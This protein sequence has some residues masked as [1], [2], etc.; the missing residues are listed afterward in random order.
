MSD[1]PRRGAQPTWPVLDALI[2]QVYEA[3]LDPTLWDDTLTGITTALGPLEWDLAFLIW[4]RNQ[5]PGA[6]FVGSTGLAAWVP[7]IYGTVYA[8]NNPW[9]RRIAPLRSGTVVDTDELMTR[10]EFT[11]SPLYR[12]FLSRWGLNRALAVVLDRR[13]DER[14]ALVLPG[15][16]DRDL[17][18]LRRGLRVLAPHIQRAVRISHRI[19]QAE[20]R[21]D[22]ASTAA[23][24]TASAI[25]CLAPDLTVITANRHVARYEASQ[26][27]SLA[28]GRLAYLEPASQA[29]LVALARSTPPAGAAFVSPDADG[30]RIATVAARVPVQTARA[31][32]GTVKGAGLIVSIGGGGEARTLEISRVA[33]WFGLTPAE[34]RLASGLAAG[35][36]LQDYCA[37][38]SVSLNAGRFLLKG[39][40]RKTEVTTQA[41]LMALVSQLPQ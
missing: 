35:A 27:I 12:D 34:A 2:G 20:L 16:G 9:S 1:R 29:E 8:A 26:V 15:P 21:A 28:G 31:L 14:L 10:E 7:Q 17:D 37:L 36:S 38:R 5:P 41:Q 25:L 6:R 39:I 13:G 22:A 19:A 18:G 24:R 4:E 40:F 11:D 30:S 32:G 23:D 33:A 3:A